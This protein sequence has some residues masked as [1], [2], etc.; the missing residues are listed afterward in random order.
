M[1]LSWL[2]TDFMWNSSENH[3]WWVYKLIWV[4][5]LLELVGWQVAGRAR[6]Q[7][8]YVNVCALIAYFVFVPRTNLFWWQNVSLEKFLEK[9]HSS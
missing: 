8:Q 1:S 4:Y 9:L 6:M 7:T 2:D 3:V 5:K